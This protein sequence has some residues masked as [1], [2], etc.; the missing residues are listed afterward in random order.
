[1]EIADFG[2]K[3]RAARVSCGFGLNAT[4]EAVGISQPTIC[5]ME[6]GRH[7]VGMDKVM[8]LLEYYHKRL[9][10]AEDSN[11]YAFSPITLGDVTKCMI[12]LRLQTGLSVE[13]FADKIGFT[14]AWVRRMER[15][16]VFT[17]EYLCAIA[18]AFDL[19]FTI[20]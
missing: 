13:S 20:E 4:A 10:I 19:T 5:S 12:A 15:G 11:R 7:S 8:T 6:S 9:L 2:E 1:M 14:G 3:M 17:V 16:G 18:T